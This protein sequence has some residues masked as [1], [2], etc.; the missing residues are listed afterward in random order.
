[1]SSVLHSLVIDGICAGVGSVL[2]LCSDYCDT[3]FSSCQCLRTAGIWQRVAFVMDKLLRKI[4]L[5]SVIVPMLIGFGCTVPGSYGKQKPLPSAR[6][7]K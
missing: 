7:R 3:V 6:D 1:M 4:G 2:S 5:S